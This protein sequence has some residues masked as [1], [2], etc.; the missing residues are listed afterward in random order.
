MISSKNGIQKLDK[1][2]CLN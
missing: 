2:N 1:K